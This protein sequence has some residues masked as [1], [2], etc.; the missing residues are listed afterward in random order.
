M[1]FARKTEKT[2]IQGF[3]MTHHAKITKL[4]STHLSLGSVSRFRGCDESSKRSEWRTTRLDTEH[5]FL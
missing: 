5:L 4:H 3:A 1:E 2:Y